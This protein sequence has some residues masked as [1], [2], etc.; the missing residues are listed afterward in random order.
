M[1]CKDLMQGKLFQKCTHLLYCSE[2]SLG[3]N[4]NTRRM[5]KPD[6]GSI[7][8]IN[9]Q[10]NILVIG[11][12]YV[13]YQNYQNSMLLTSLDTKRMLMQGCNARKVNWC[14]VYSAYILKDGSHIRLR[15]LSC[16]YITAQR[17]YTA[18]QKNPYT[19]EIT[20]L[21]LHP[22]TDASILVYKFRPKRT[23]FNMYAEYTQLQLTFLALKSW[24]Y[25]C[26]Y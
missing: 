16:V 26:L 10:W 8:Q 2:L 4:V 22:C 15:H 13:N 21:A 24:W 23:G 6:M 1:V 20:F 7:F 19:S 3:G 5:S 14:R 12:Y 11:N 18:V 9:S 17:Q 25:V